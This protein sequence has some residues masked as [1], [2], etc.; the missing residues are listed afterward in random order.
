MERLLNQVFTEVFCDDDRVVFKRE[1]GTGFQ[2]AHS[3]DCCE[4][5]WVGEISG[6]L[7]DLIGTPILSAEESY[8][9]NPEA[10]ESG[11]Y[12]FYRLATIKGYVQ[13][14]FNGYSNG[15]YSETA[16]LY[17]FPTDTWLYR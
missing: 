15:Y 3:Q 9:N 13:I 8:E 17:E 10:S 11:T 12:S 16:A 7:D 6:D 2:L 14:R 1:D 5:V 4:S